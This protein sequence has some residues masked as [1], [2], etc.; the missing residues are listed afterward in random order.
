MTS[1]PQKRRVRKTRP[2]AQLSESAVSAPTEEVIAEPSPH[3]FA[4]AHSNG[5][6]YLNFAP[7]VLD[8]VN[9]IR[10]EL[11]ITP[12]K[13]EKKFQALGQAIVHDRKCM[14]DGGASFVTLTFL[15][16]SEKI[17]K[18]ETIDQI[19][20]RWMSDP[21]RRPVLLGPGDKAWISLETME[22]EDYA[23][24]AVASIYR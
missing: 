19:L 2:S 21:S 5:L 15:S 13:I 23:V 20:T 8:R 9:G 18:S 4:T 7:C 10:M 3:E 24:F 11:G 17:D 1:V 6:D 22:D 12:L 14:L 16:F